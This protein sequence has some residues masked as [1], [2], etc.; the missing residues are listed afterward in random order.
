MKFERSSG[1]LLHITS[2]PGR[3]GIG[4]FGAGAHD[5]IDLL[6]Q[7]GC[8]YWQFLP[9]T[10]PGTGNS[11][12]S[13]ISAFAWNPRLI[14]PD[15]LW[16]DGYIKKNDVLDV[17]FSSEKVEY[18]KVNLWK[19]RLIEMAL[20]RK[21][22]LR[23]EF[24]EY[25]TTND[26]WIDDYALYLAIKER[27]SGNKWTK[28]PSLI[29]NRDKDTL[30]ITRESLK[31][32]IINHKFV[33]Y[34]ISRQWHRLRMY[35]VS[36]GI[37][38]IGDLPLYI[39]HDSSDVWANP[40]LFKLNRY[41]NPSFVSGVPPDYFTEDGQLWGNP[42]YD[43]TANQKNNYSWWLERFEKNLEQFDLLRIDHFR[44]YSK[45]WEIP[46]G[47]ISARKGEWVTGPGISIFNAL[48]VKKGGSTTLPFIAEDLGL[49]DQE[50][51]ELR[52]Q[53]DIPGMK[54][55]QFSFLDGKWEDLPEQYPEN[56]IVYIGTHDNDTIRGWIKNISVEERKNIL[57]FLKKKGEIEVK[58]LIEA[59]WKT[60]SCIAIVPMQDILTLDSTARMNIPSVQ[61][62]NW[63][64][65]MDVDEA[66][67]EEKKITL[68]ELNSKFG[69]RL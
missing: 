40:W 1:I 2:L 66:V 3:Y 26:Y 14:S 54:N 53:I 60:R 69:R 43:W 61:D 67:L 35:A 11:P 41:G 46:A 57:R 68:L 48:K 64:W 63:E 50:V 33:Q 52:R 59:A 27:F 29:K 19:D 55:I 22:N 51:L 30:I 65:R 45:Y 21:D 13:G 47:E 7:A 36:R 31:E 8:R 20:E 10:Y 38:L 28:W 17:N 32:E 5:F 58:D 12:Y 62:N 4:D 16:Q 15:L 34:L 42:V 39:S 18:K 9:L 49:I 24:E 25:C 37:K 44:G 6:S 56:S 23:D